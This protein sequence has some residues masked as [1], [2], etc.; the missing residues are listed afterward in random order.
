MIIRKISFANEHDSKKTKTKGFAR[1]SYLHSKMKN[2]GACKTFWRGEKRF[3]YVSRATPAFR[4]MIINEYWFAFQNRNPTRD[5]VSGLLL[6][7]DPIGFSQHGLRRR[8]TLRP[9]GVAHQIFMYVH[10]DEH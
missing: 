5:Q 4:I 2:K 3:R 7:C 6:V 9:R 1:A 10:I 8:R